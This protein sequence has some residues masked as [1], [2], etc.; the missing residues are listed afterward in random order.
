M[1][2]AIS[3]RNQCSVIT[4]DAGFT[5]VEI[6]VAI[7][8]SVVL[9]AGVGQIYVSSKESFRVQ[10][11]NARLQEN[12]R[13]AMEF[14][15]RDIRQAG[16]S[17]DNTVISPIITDL[18]QTINGT[19]DTSDQITISFQSPTDCLGANTP[20]GVAINTYSIQNQQLMCRGNGNAV[21]QPIAD[22]IE[23]M[24]ILY[25]ENTDPPTL[26]LPPTANRYR[27]ADEANLST[28]VSVR[29]ALLFRSEAA[30]KSTAVRQA[31]TLLGAAE[32][33]RTDRF[34]RQVVTT[35]IPLRNM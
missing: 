10:H 24:Q 27:N 31:Y 12:Q 16:F 5:L 28:V 13:I 18:T 9:L 34:K 15:N 6:M 32:I 21:A 1:S 26:G 23:N 11:I 19:G 20:D 35:T 7:T 8:L 33:E 25:G 29:I 30:I 3:S 4:H 17:D 2:K 22:N 14:L